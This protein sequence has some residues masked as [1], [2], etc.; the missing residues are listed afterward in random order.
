M[1]PRWRA[2]DGT[3]LHYTPG[4]LEVDEI[5]DMVRCHLCG[6]WWQSVGSHARHEHGLTAAA[7]RESAVRLA[8]PRRQPR[9]SRR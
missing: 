7:S 3:P 1:K 5:D 6:F 4:T 2:S 8:A 9:R